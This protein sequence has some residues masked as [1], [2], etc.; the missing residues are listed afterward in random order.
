MD[1]LNKGKFN[2]VPM[3]FGY[4]S[5]EGLLFEIVRKTR[6]AKILTNLEYEIPYNINVKFGSTES[7]EIAEKIKKFYFQ[8]EE[9]GENSIDSVYSVC[10]Q[11]FFINVFICLYFIYS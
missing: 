2:K 5:Q 11:L 10:T 6:N 7:R 1:I 9:I 8:D 4:N 3:I